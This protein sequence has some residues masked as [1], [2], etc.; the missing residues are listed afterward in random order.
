MV[1]ALTLDVVQLNRRSWWR[2]QMK[3]FSALLTICAGNS[4][5]PGEFPAQ[6]PVTRSFDVCF[7]LHPYKRLS[8]QCWGW[9]FE[10]LSCSLWRHRDVKSAHQWI[11]TSRKKAVTV[12]AYPFVDF[13]YNTLMK[14]V[15]TTNRH[16]WSHTLT[17]ADNFMMAVAGTMWPK[18]FCLRG[19]CPEYN[20][21]PDC[22]TRFV[23][24]YM[25]R[26]PPKLESE[27]SSLN[28][29]LPGLNGRHFADAFSNA[30]SRMKIFVFRFEFHWSLSKGF[31]WE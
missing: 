6:R 4:P 12:T 22:H 8:K 10:T 7:H 17:S 5:V 25:Y 24:S 14:G 18:G 26:A 11:I 9:W 16:W 3:T 21:K 13:S 2:H 30:F 23:N 31:N 28:L 19:L 20:C 1:P 29:P 27:S 15:Q